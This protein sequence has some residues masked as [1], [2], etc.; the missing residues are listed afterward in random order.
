[1]PD[2]KQ[3]ADNLNFGDDAHFQ[4]FSHKDKSSR[5]KLPM[6]HV[7]DKSASIMLQH[8]RTFIDSSL[9]NKVRPNSL[10]RNFENQG[11]PTLHSYRPKPQELHSM[12]MY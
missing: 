5:K 4:T 12:T 7:R 8:A 6:D 3:P 1:M 9:E 11:P 10:I 2:M